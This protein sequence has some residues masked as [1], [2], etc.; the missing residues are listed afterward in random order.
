MRCTSVS[1]IGV[2]DPNYTYVDIIGKD[3]G[4]LNFCPVVATLHHEGNIWGWL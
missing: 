1:C 4:K 3:I 2:F